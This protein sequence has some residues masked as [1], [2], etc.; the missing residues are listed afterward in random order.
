VEDAIDAEYSFTRYLAAKAAIDDRAL[1]RDVWRHLAAALDAAGPAGQPVDVLEAGAGIG[2]MVERFSHWYRGRP[3]HYTAID[4]QEENV[5]EAGRRLLPRPGLEVTLETADIFDFARRKRGTRAWDLLIA[6]AFLDL[7]DVPRALPALFGLL[8]PGG[9]FYFTMVFDGA[10]I[11]EP[12]IDPAFDS[13]V[14]ALYHCTMDERLVQGQQSGDSRAGRHMFGHL[15]A[16]GGELMAAGSSDWVVHPLGGGYP[17]GEAY[18]LHHIVDT[19][20]RA[21]AGRPEVDPARFGAWI[22]RRHAQVEAGELVYVAHQLD[23]LGQVPAGDAETRRQGDAE[24]DA[25]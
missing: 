19:V 12:A 22:D 15:R 21:L 20:H 1:N 4:A 25:A 8:R 23:F 7:V 16:A 24:M 3:L 2:T 5:A 17:P 10:T 11:L 18:F 6:H 13:H 9:L 14:E